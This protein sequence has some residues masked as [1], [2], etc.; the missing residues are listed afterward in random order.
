VSVDDKNARF[1]NIKDCMK[2]RK[3][4]LQFFSGVLLADLLPTKTS[5]TLYKTCFPTVVFHGCV[6]AG[7]MEI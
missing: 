3:Y 6:T 1:S 7:R 5:I 2:F 4:S